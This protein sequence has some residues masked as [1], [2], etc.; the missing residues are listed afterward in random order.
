MKNLMDLTS[1]WEKGDFAIF[2]LATDDVCVWHL[3]YVW[4][5]I[6]TWPSLCVRSGV[7]SNDALCICSL[8][9]RF[10]WNQMSIS[11][12]NS[13]KL[14]VNQLHGLWFYSNKLIEL[15]TWMINKRK[16][17]GKFVQLID[18]M[19]LPNPFLYEL[20]P[21]FIPFCQSQWHGWKKWIHFC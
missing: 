17:N 8:W 4:I 16:K 20:K 9:Q 1:V 6:G 7:Y 15:L 14:H 18:F 2:F 13:T 10:I 12:R 19:N 5:S 3:H 11:H 21:D